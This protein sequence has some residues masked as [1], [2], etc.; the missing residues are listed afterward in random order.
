MDIK[1]SISPTCSNTNEKKLLNSNLAK[2]L[3]VSGNLIVSYL[4]EKIFFNIN[5]FTM[6]WHMK[7]EKLSKIKQSTNQNS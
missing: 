5:K 2:A 4:E 7:K 1:I 3:K 6:P